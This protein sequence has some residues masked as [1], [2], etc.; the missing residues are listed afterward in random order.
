MKFLRV[1]TL[2]LFCGLL[3]GLLC[4]APARA[5]SL[6]ISPNPNPAE[7][8]PM[9]GD[10]ARNGINTADPNID[11]TRATWA[12]TGASQ[13]MVRI[14]YREGPEEC[15]Y[16]DNFNNDGGELRAFFVPLQ[17]SDEWAAFAA[18]LPGGVRLRYGCPGGVRKD[19]CGNEFVLPDMPASD[20]PNDI[21]HILTQG[22]YQ[23]QFACP[24]IGQGTDGQMLNT[25]CGELGVRR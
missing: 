21:V 12:C 25:G 19:P 17:T 24:A 15:V 13:Q 4:S 7:H 20:N 16:I 1:F 18:N 10:C 3:A 5:N 14:F 6:L 23:A 22:D 11:L 9:Q 8:F 2:V